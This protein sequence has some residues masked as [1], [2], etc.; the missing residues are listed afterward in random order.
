V[1]VIDSVGAGDAFC[2]ALALRPAIGDALHDAVRYANAAGAF[3]CTRH[4]AEPSMP[5]TDDV[6][7]VLRGVRA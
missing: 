5:R 2:A 3:A 6:E 4:G 1:D 7:S